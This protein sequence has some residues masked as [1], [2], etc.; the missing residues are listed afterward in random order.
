MMLYRVFDGM[1]IVNLGVCTI[2]MCNH[3]AAW[4]ILLRTIQDRK[5]KKRAERRFSLLFCNVYSRHKPG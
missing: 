1:G 3:G 4:T 2:R 5:K